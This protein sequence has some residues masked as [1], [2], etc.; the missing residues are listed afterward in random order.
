M[1]KITRSKAADKGMTRY[2]SGNKCI[3]GHISE[4][5]VS[6]G[7]CAKCLAQR[8]KQWRKTGTTKGAH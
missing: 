4:R 7:I 6:N 2:Y 5:L 1:E 3:N 8:V